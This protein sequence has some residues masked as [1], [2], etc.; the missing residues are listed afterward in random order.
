MDQAKV[1]ALS[2]KIINAKRDLASCQDDITWNQKR[3][4]E[5]SAECTRRQAEYYPNIESLTKKVK[6]HKQELIELCAEMEAL[7]LYQDPTP[8]ETVPP[9][10]TTSFEPTEVASRET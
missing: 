5:I 1:I 4:D 2:Q 8:N 9:V 6:L 3:I 10:S 7:A